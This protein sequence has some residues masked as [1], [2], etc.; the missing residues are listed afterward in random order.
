MYSTSTVPRRPMMLSKQRTPLRVRLRRVML[1][2][3]RLLGEHHLPSLLGEDRI[4]GRNGD[5]VGVDY[6]IE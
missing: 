3:H 6:F 2:G 1:V 5:G 4:V